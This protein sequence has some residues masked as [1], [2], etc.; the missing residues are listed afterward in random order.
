M[1]RI[2][3][4]G[5][6]SGCS[7]VANGRFRFSPLDHPF[8]LAC[9]CVAVFLRAAFCSVGPARVRV[10]GV[11]RNVSR[12]AAVK[13]RASVPARSSGYPAVCTPSPHT[14][15]APRVRSG[16]FHTP[17]PIAILVISRVFTRVNGFSI[18]C[19]V[20]VIF[21]SSRG[22]IF[23]RTLLLRRGN[24]EGFLTFAPLAPLC[25]LAA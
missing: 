16:S 15:S 9:Y 11:P 20:L 6:S 1:Y 19:V 2:S 10:C 4:Y 24:P 8:S 12:A 3:L 14:V 22:N 7:S 18:N 17:M 21:A 13:P 5:Y 25:L 23:T